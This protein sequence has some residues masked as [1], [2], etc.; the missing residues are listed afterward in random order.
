VKD[1]VFFLLA[2]YGF[3]LALQDKKIKG[4]GLCLSPYSIFEMV[5][6]LKMN[7]IWGAPFS[8]FVPTEDEQ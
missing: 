4:N 8:I 2:P 6:G 1:G 7:S 5:Q 3:G